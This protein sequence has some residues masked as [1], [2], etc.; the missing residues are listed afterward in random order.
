MLERVAD[1]G[2]AQSQPAG[3]ALRSLLPPDLPSKESH[4]AHATACDPRATILEAS[5]SVSAKVVATRC[6]NTPFSVVGQRVAALQ[7][8]SDISERLRPLRDRWVAQLPDK[9][10]A[11]GINFP[12]I[13]M[14]VTKIGYSDPDLAKDLSQGVPIVG[15]VKASGVRTTRGE[16]EASSAEDWRKGIPPRNNL[17]FER[18]K[19]PRGTGEA[20]ER[21]EQTVGEIHRGWLS[22]PTP[23]SIEAMKTTP[24]TPRYAP[25]E[26]RASG[27]KYRLVDD[28]RASGANDIVSPEDTD[29]PHNVD[30]CLALAVLYEHIHPGIQLY[31]FSVDYAH[32]YK[33]A[34]CLEAK[35]S[36]RR[37]SYSRWKATR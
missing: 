16:K 7:T 21:W 35:A 11:A 3:F 32:A 22:P 6:V 23:I 9:S 20:R 30:T 1:A 28:F 13:S 12:L 29:A 10:P 25:K 31:A 36:S 26:A 4:I 15:R 17:N 37:R 24:L 5:T 8:L 14:L 33:H 19:M 2:A 18:V 34:P 27:T